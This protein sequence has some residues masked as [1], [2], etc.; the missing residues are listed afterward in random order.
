MRKL[1]SGADLERYRSELVAKTVPQ[2]PTLVISAGTCGALASELAIGDLVVPETVLTP[3]RVPRAT[4][5]LPGLESSG[6]LLTLGRIAAS[7]AAKARLHE[8]TG[9]VAVDMESATI[10]DWA[11]ARGI[12]AGVVRAVSDTAAQSL[13]A[14]L[15]AAVYPDG[16][17]RRLRAL[18]AILRRRGALADAL[19]L[20]RATEAALDTVARSLELVLGGAAVA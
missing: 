15:T 9:A 14:D 17:V 11:R 20:R 4:G 12:T 10:L 18:L 7:P 8:A 13:P 19:A 3:T 16:R 1:S 6:T 5:P 2:L